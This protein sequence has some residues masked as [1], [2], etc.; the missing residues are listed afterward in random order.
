MFGEFSSMR[1]I[2]ANTLNASP[3]N[4]NDWLR[5]GAMEHDAPRPKHPIK[6]G[7]G[8]TFVS[9]RFGPVGMTKVFRKHTSAE[10]MMRCTDWCCELGN[11]FW[12]CHKQV[13][14]KR[15]QLSFFAT[16]RAG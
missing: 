14:A 8:D 4:V 1:R 2:A 6:L 15:L 3:E 9:W 5:L 12:G 11:G 10:A 7:R 16:C 13:Q